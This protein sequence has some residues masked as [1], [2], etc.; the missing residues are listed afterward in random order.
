ME[1]E[2]DLLQRRTVRKIREAAEFAYSGVRT[3]HAY[4]ELQ[5]GKILACETALGK[6]GLFKETCYYYCLVTVGLHE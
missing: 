2:K 4:R 6:R 1:R 5:E 3:E